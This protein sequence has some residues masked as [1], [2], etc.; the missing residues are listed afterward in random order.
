MPLTLASRM[1][2]C[3]CVYMLIMTQSMRSVPTALMKLEAQKS[4][5]SVS[6]TAYKGLRWSAVMR[7]SPRVSME[8]VLR[9]A[10]LVEDRY[11]ACMRRHGAA[12]V[13]RRVETREMG[14][15]MLSLRRAAPRP[16]GGTVRVTR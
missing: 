14:V 11:T 6:H 10:R 15:C 13:F 8:P 16:S 3:V 7:F 1:S 9:V 2:V 12:G 5:H 4:K